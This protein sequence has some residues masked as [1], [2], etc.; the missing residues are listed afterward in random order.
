MR[1]A[2][3]SLLL[4]CLGSAASAQLSVIPQIGLENSKTSLSSNGAS[5]NSLGSFAM[6]KANLRLEYL[7]KKAHGAYVGFGT[8]PAVATISTL[9]PETIADN[10]TSS[11]GKTKWRLEAGYQLSTKPINFKKSSGQ[12]KTASASSSQSQRSSCMSGY[13]S[14]CGKSSYSTARTAKKNDSWNMRIQP[15]AGIAYTPAANNEFFIDNTATGTVYNYKAGNWNTA[16]TAGI[17]FAFAKG[18]N[19]KFII[20]LQHLRG[21]GN[22]DNQTIKAFSEGK[23]TSTVVDSRASTWSLSFGIPLALT[24]QKTKAQPVRV[25]PQQKTPQ[26]RSRCGS[27]SRCT[28]QI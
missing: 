18:D 13:R 28:R 21:L 22:L 16:V 3:P 27:Y 26:Y 7:F 12:Q 4:L 2:L 15:S 24:K 10:Y 23:T 14:G 5:F 11:L 1:K 17:N 19:R 9:S 25:Q 6:P 20:G 8:S